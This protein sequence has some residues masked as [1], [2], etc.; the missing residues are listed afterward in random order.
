MKIDDKAKTK[1][2]IVGILIIIVLYTIGI[3]Y[4]IKKQIMSNQNQALSE[5]YNKG[6][7]FGYKEGYEEGKKILSEI[8]QSPKDTASDTEISDL[9]E[10]NDDAL[11]EKENDDDNLSITEDTVYVTKSGSKYHKQDCHTLKGNGSPISVTDAESNGKTP[12][13]ICFK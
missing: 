8:Y 6:Y 9:V 2:V 13:K 12:C 1:L 3:E 4:S 11:I 7:E 10:N 5:T